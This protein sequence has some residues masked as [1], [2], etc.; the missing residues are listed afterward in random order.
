MSRRRNNS[1]VKGGLAGTR[2]ADDQA[3]DLQESADLQNILRSREA[4]AH[5]GLIAC[6]QFETAL[7]AWLEFLI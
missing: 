3:H 5:Q 2:R 1:F 6:I 4:L 7:A